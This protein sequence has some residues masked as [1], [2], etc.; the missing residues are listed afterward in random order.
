MYWG[1]KRLSR[2]YTKRGDQD[3]IQF[4]N[5]T[6]PRV[7]N[8]INAYLEQRFENIKGSDQTLLAMSVFDIALSGQM[9]GW[10]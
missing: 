8:C 2:N 4:N 3:L 7:I 5:T 10:H 1:W 6:N 9:I